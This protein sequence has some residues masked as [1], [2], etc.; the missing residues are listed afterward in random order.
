M[1]KKSLILIVLISAAMG[2]LQ[3]ALE[4]V[5]IPLEPVI[6]HIAAT[7]E[8]AKNWDGHDLALAG[9]GALALFLGYRKVRK[10]FGWVRLPSTR[11]V[12][13]KTDIYAIRNARKEIKKILGRIKGRSKKGFYRYAHEFD[14]SF[15]QRSRA[16]VC[17]ALTRRGILLSTLNTEENEDVG[18]RGTNFTFTWRRGEGHR[19]PEANVKA[20]G[21]LA[22]NFIATALGL[23]SA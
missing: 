6:Q 11:D 12:Q 4:A 9:M 13:S 15:G 16:A 20:S 3:S 18:P 17:A 10:A 8:T 22:N 21:H 19:Y 14:R 23:N 7:V 5:G 1:I 2:Y